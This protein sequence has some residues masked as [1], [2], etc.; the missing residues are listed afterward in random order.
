MKKNTLLF[1]ALAFVGCASSVTTS[2]D[3]DR[4]IDFSRY[5]TY[6]WLRPAR[7]GNDILERRLTATI[8]RELTSRGLTRSDTPDLFVMIHGRLGKEVQ[9]TAFDTG[10]G[11]G[12]RRWGAGPTMVRRQEVPVGTLFVDLVDA[13]DKEL[14]W[15]GTAKTAIDT[16][17]TAEKREADVAEA[18]GKLF[19]AFP[20]RR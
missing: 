11:Y 20:P 3:Y 8:D 9:Y 19:A 16:T 15:R 12:W 5:R 17:S 6:G 18:V 7:L 13:G 1:L 14:V 2:I 10:W 4:S